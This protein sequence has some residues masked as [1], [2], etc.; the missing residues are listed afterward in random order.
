MNLCDL[1]T[2]VLSLIYSYADPETTWIADKVSKINANSNGWI[3]GCNSKSQNFLNK[4]I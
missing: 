4:N 3:I 2:D 1:P